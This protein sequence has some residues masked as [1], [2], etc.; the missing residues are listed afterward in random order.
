MLGRYLH[1][2]YFSGRANKSRFSYGS[3]LVLFNILNGT[4][5]IILGGTPYNFG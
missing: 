5:S 3:Y 2:F 1:F 4:A